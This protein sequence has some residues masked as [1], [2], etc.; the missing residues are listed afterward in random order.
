MALHMGGRRSP[1]YYCC[2]VMTDLLAGGT[3]ARLYN[4][5]VKRRRLFS[6][7][8]SYITGD[9][10]PGLFI[11]TGQLMP[12][13]ELR[14]GEEALWNQ[15]E[16]L[17]SEPVGDDE[18]QK[19]RNKFEA[20]M[21]YGEMNVMNKALNLAYY[22]LLGELP[23]VNSELEI[24]R[25]VEAGQIMETARRLFRRDRSSTLVIYGKHGE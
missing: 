4:E 3:S 8:N 23:L 25:G 9:I 17:C 21:L 20:N 7:V 15:L 5:L 22:A 6:A 16:R 10:D 13:V 18:L 2:D 14:E 19:V 24:Y 12:G 11:L 1:E